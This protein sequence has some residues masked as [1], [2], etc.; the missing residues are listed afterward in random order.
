[1][2]LLGLPNP[3]CVGMYHGLMSFLRT[4]Q[5]PRAS[6]SIIDCGCA[7]LFDIVE[8]NAAKE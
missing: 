4:L 2:T 6:V 7:V 1:M 8:A 5:I 3:G